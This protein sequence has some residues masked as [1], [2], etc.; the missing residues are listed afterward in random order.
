MFMLSTSGALN[1]F[2]KDAALLNR[3]TSVAFSSSFSAKGYTITVG[4]FYMLS[5]SWISSAK[6]PKNI[7]VELTL[8]IST[9][10]EL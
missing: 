4:G 10:L 5:V 6:F 9:T 7:G 2:V 8:E 3:S 1:Y